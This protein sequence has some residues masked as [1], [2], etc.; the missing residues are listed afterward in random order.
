[1]KC[2]HCKTEV[3]IPVGQMPQPVDYN[4]WK[5]TVPTGEEATTVS[6]LSCKTCGGTIQQKPGATAGRCVFCK[7][8]YSAPPAPAQALRPHAVL[9]FAIEKEDASKRLNTWISK[10]RFAP[11]ALKSQASVD[12]LEGVYLPVWRYDA[13]STTDYVGERGEHRTETQTVYRDGKPETETKTVTDW[14]GASGTVDLPFS[15]VDVVAGVGI[16]PSLESVLQGAARVG[17]KPYRDEYAYGFSAQTYKVGLKEGWERATHQMEPGIEKAVRS[18]I[19]GDEQ[20][21]HRKHT[22]YSA[23]AFLLLM[24]P[25]WVVAY[26][27]EGKTYQVVVDGRSGEIKGKRPF[28]RA[29]IISLVAAIVILIV[30]AVVLL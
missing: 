2:R 23:I 8:P 22:V 24:V 9:P 21:V 20:R 12:K 4:R 15:D 6:E 25:A 16:D 19:G 13:D 30:V 5:D 7:A 3:P 28:S 27:F 26:R 17:L 18:D 1:M 14:Y 11:R 29:K 10:R